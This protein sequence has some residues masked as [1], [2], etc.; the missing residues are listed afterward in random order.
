M[1]QLGYVE[2]RNV[3]FEYRFADGVI[4]RLPGLAV[5]LVAL[6]PNVILSG[7]LP[8]NLAVQK[9]T[10][11]IPI[12]MGTGADPVGFGTILSMRAGKVDCGQPHRRRKFRYPPTVGG[13]G[14]IGRHQ[15]CIDVLPC[16]RGKGR[17]QLLDS[18]NLKGH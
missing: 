18:L 9:A 7:P 17:L 15:E 5:E 10:S 13:K 2:G 4:D 16:K 8:A 12:V 11:T 1:R 14:C 6:N 3:R